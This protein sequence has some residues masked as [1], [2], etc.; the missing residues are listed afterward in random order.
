MVWIAF[1]ICCFV[2]LGMSTRLSEHAKKTVL[3]LVIGV[4]LGVVF[5][6]FRG[7]G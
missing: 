7:D 3:F 6:G 1:L 2:A 5:I 4:T